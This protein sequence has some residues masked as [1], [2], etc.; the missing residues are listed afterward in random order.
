MP[1]EQNDTLKELGRLAAERR[2]EA[3]LTLQDIYERT[4]IRIEYLNGIETGNYDGFPCG[5][6]SGRILV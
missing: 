1:I 2:E 3:H 6:L 5:A 4:K